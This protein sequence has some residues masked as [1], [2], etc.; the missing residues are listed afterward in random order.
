MEKVCVGVHRPASSG[1]RRNSSMPKL[2]SVREKKSTHLW[3]SSSTLTKTLQ[4]L[5]VRDMARSVV[6]ISLRRLRV[7]ADRRTGAYQIAV[8]IDVVNAS[9]RRPVFVLTRA[10][11]GEAALR[12]RIRPLP[13]I[14]GDVMHGVRCIAQRRSFHRHAAGLYLGDLAAD[15]DHRVAEAIKLGLGF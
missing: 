9:D 11:V 8:A 7:I 15:R 2:P 3:S 12:A 1:S 14:V 4:R 5:S 10:A 6:P 13:V